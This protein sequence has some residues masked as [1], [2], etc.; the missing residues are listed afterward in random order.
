M[1]IIF[2]VSTVIG[3]LGAIF[4]LVFAITQSKKERDLKRHVEESSGSGQ[5]STGETEGDSDLPVT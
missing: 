2:I 4:T 3:T 5:V 1:K